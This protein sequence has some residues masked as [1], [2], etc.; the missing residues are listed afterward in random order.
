MPTARPSSRHQD[1]AARLR[2]ARQ[3]RAHLSPRDTPAGAPR[4]G[5][6][7]PVRPPTH[8]RSAQP[9]SATGRPLE[10]HRAPAQVLRSDRVVLS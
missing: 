3:R 4:R 8:G 5:R 9:K 7:S 1:T 6:R 10:C 2:D